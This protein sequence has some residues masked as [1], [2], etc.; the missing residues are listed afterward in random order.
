MN[1]SVDSGGVGHVNSP[2]KMDQSEWLDA[3]AVLDFA[4]EDYKDV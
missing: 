2:Y 1:P 4:C 3:G